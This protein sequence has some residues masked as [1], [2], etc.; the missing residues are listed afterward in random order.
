MDAHS[1]LDHAASP[2]HT[3]LFPDHVGDGPSNY[4]PLLIVSD[5]IPGNETKALGIKTWG[6]DQS[7]GKL[8]VPHPLF[9]IPGVPSTG[10]HYGMGFGFHK[11]V[12]YR[13]RAREIRDE[14]MNHTTDPR[15]DGR[16]HKRTPIP[17]PNALPVY[18]FDQ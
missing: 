3:P 15:L 5:M 10:A 17:I 4:T 2:Y 18:Y 13:N 6:A 14:L 12:H 7:L 1:F 11:S 16:L 8:A 9:T